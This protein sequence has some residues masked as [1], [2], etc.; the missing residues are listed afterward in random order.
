MTAV[1]AFESF[2]D[3]VRLYWV[4]TVGAEVQAI[5]LSGED[6]WRT[7]PQSPDDNHLI[8][9]A[10]S[11]HGEQ[12]AKQWHTYLL[13]MRTGEARPI[14][15]FR[16][17]QILL[18]S[19]WSPDGTMLAYEVGPTRA[20]PGGY[21]YHLATGDITSLPP[22]FP[23]GEIPPEWSP[24]VYYGTDACQTDTAKK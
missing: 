2:Y 22:V 18:F 8:L 5:D 7:G 10:V 19:S 4:D 9:V 20:Q 3:G 13:D 16:S 23:G 17:E 14:D 6:I 21:I 15:Q 12:L 24:R 1:D 11:Y